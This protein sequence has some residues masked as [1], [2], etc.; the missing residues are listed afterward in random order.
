MKDEHVHVS[1]SECGEILDVS[2]STQMLLKEAEEKS[3]FK[4]NFASVTFDGL[5]VNCQA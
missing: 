4:L 1:C 3:D 5:C 2:L